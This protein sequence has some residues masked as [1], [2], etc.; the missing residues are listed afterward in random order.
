MSMVLLDLGADLRITQLLREGTVG[1]I[2]PQIYPHG[3]H[4][5]TGWLNPA[6][7]KG[8][9]EIHTHQPRPL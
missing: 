6:A 7:E 9:Q 8:P 4:P 1:A 3:D 5:L 2:W